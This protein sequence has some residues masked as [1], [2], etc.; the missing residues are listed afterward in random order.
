VGNPS[1]SFAA[2]LGGLVAVFERIRHSGRKGATE[3]SAKSK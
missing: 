2:W 3:S 1:L